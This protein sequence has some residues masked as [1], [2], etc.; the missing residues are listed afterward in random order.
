MSG[1]NKNIGRYPALQSWVDDFWGTTKML[2]EQFWNR[3]NWP[4]VN[5]REGDAFYEVEVAAPGMTK[6]DFTITVDEG[7]L[8]IHA[9]KKE[10]EEVVEENFTLREFNATSFTRAFNLPANVKEDGVKAEYSDGLLRIHLKKEIVDNPK[11]KKVKI[12]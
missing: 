6:S 3:T 12:S 9:E 8:S 1:K 2:G 4:A 7:I 10:E 11:K 5:I